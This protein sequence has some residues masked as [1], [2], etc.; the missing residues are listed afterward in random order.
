MIVITLDF[1]AIEIGKYARGEPLLLNI[2]FSDGQDKVIQKS[3]D[4]NNTELLTQEIINETKKLAKESNKSNTGNFLDDTVMIRFARD[5]EE[6]EAKLN[7]ALRRIKEDVRKFKTT[8]SQSYL[9]KWA[10]FQGTKYN[11]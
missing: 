5:E 10:M 8:N 2:S 9:Q 11:I 7:M 3:T 6:T 4:L 1:K